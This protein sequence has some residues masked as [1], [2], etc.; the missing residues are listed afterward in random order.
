MRRDR[1]VQLQI[2]DLCLED[3]SQVLLAA[4]A[5]LQRPISL[6]L[7]HAH[8]WLSTATQTSS[9][10]AVPCTFS[11]CSSRQQGLCKVRWSSEELAF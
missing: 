4:D 2:A 3:S 11:S 10:P 1:H 8:W 6:A 7:Q 9:P 5:S